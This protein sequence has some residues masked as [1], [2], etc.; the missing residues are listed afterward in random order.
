MPDISNIAE[1]D[2]RSIAESLNHRHRRLEDLAKD[3]NAGL[4]ILREVAE[5]RL[6]ALGIGLPTLIAIGNALIDTAPAAAAV[7][8]RAC[9]RGERAAF[10]HWGSGVPYWDCLL[11]TSPS[12]RD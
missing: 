6:D 12:P 9:Q 3:R 10:A 1:A 8:V 7:Y 11:Y 5:G 2:V 4:R